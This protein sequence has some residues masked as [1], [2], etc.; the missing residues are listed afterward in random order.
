MK[1]VS[2]FFGLFFL[3]WTLDM[4]ICVVAMFSLGVISTIALWMFG[5]NDID[6]KRTLSYNFLNV[7]QDIFIVLL[8]NVLRSYNQTIINALVRSVVSYFYFN[9]YLNIFIISIPAILVYG[10][11]LFDILFFKLPQFNLF[12][13]YIKGF[14]TILLIS[15]PFVISTLTAPYVVY[16]WKGEVFESR[17]NRKFREQMAEKKRTQQ[18]EDIPEQPWW[19]K[20]IGPKESLLDFCC[21]RFQKRSTE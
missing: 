12:S 8:I 16:F 9:I 5:P 21:K 2:R 3:E 6:L 11:F 17:I 15:L 20:G 19:E 4:V 14:Y 1:A 18:H 13:S 10:F 7:F